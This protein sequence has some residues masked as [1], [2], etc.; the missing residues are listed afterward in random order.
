[1]FYAQSTIAVISGRKK[2]KKKKNNNNNNNNNQQLKKK[3]KKKKKNKNKNKNNNNNNNNNNQQ[4]KKKKKTAEPPF[5]CLSSSSNCTWTTP[6]PE[7]HFPRSFR[8][9]PEP[10]V[11]PAGTPEALVSACVRGGRTPGPARSRP[12][13][14]SLPPSGRFPVKS[15][16]CNIV[17]H[18]FCLLEHYLGREQFSW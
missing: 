1:M 8:S 7:T 12:C 13:S 9:P 2:K 17:V 4:L 14:T 16:H 11:F 3:K 10:S 15:V 5:D 18:R 6:L